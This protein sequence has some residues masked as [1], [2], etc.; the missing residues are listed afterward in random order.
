MAFFIGEDLPE[1]SGIGV[2]H[3]K[4]ESLKATLELNKYSLSS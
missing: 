3:G 4:K 2:E 1:S